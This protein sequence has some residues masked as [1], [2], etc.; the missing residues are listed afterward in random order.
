MAGYSVNWK[1]Q[2]PKT[3]FQREPTI[4]STINSSA[5]V[6]SM[7][8][9]KSYFEPVSI[10]N[11]QVPY[12]DFSCPKHKVSN[13]IVL[14]NSKEDPRI[15]HKHKKTEMLPYVAPPGDNYFRMVYDQSRKSLLAGVLSVTITLFSLTLGVLLI[16]LK[17]TS[18][19]FWA[20]SDLA[21]P[22]MFVGYVSGGIRGIVAVV[23]GIMALPKINSEQGKYMGKKN[24]ITGIVFA[25]ILF[26]ILTLLVV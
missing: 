16:V 25:S 9:K 22:I 2:A 20:T 11:S 23:L 14:L 7:T 21:G 26:G 17:S 15:K 5:S 10:A 12:T 6:K 1:H 3:I 13:P 24:A 19:G 18:V 8:L 4:A